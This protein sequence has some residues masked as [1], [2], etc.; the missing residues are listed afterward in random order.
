MLRPL[1]LACSVAAV[2]F[3]RTTVASHGQGQAQGGDA[4]A[5]FQRV[6]SNCHPIAR[7]TAMR[8]SH[9]QWEEV[10][11]T[12]ISARN[13]KISDEEFDIILGYLSKEYGR[14]NVNSAPANEIAEVLGVDDKLAAAIVAYRGEHGKFADFDALAEVPGIDREALEKKREAIIF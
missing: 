7:V 14:V 1:V 4:A 13:A 11:G 6:C 10:I 9:A 3:A 8:R 2:V 12:M 5:V